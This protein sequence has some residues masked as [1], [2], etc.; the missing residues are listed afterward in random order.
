MPPAVLNP[1]DDYVLLST[2]GGA[3]PMAGGAA[4]WAQPAA[5]LDALGQ[6]WLVAEFAV[7]ADWPNWEM[8]PAADELVY[9]LAGTATL[10]LDGPGGVQAVP[11]QAPGLVVVPRGVWHTAQ[12][13]GPCRFLHITMGA[14]TETRPA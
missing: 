14:G 9:L 3:T 10:L 2:G 5:A 7:D 6:G 12:V 11:L 13:A 4:F 1:Q 8:H